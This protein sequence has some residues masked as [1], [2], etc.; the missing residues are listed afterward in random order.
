MKEMENDD[1]LKKLFDRLPQEE[2]PTGLREGIIRRA[3][4]EKPRR[5]LSFEAKGIIIV[6]SILPALMAGIWWLFDYLDISLYLA[7]EGQRIRRLLENVD[8]GIYMPVIA[9]ALL[10]LVLLIIQTLISSHI[11]KKRLERI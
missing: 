4:K 7:Q 2:M 8:I 1:R 11:N 10:A 5:V 6:A 3:A 9:M